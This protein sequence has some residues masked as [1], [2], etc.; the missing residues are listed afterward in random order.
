MIDDPEAVDCDDDQ[1]RLKWFCR[2]PF[3]SKGRSKYASYVMTRR[4]ELQSTVPATVRALG[5]PL[6]NQKPPMGDLAPK[7]HAINSARRPTLGP[8]KATG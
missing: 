5:D 7:G 8:S 4:T 3:V 2:G 1:Q 6:A